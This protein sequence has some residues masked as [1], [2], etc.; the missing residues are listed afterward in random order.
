MSRI[1]CV[2]HM[3]AVTLAQMTRNAPS[4]VRKIYRP[5]D[6][7][8][9]PRSRQN[10]GAPGPRCPQ[11]RA[12]AIPAPFYPLFDPATKWLGQGKAFEYAQQNVN[13]DRVSRRPQALARQA[14][15]SPQ[16][17]GPGGGA[18]KRFSQRPSPGHRADVLA[19]SRCRRGAENAPVL[20]LCASTRR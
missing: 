19:L 20:R 15:M 2:I 10:V 1:A 4:V 9:R 3:S 17:A 14:F 6:P 12:D 16:G 7:I 11:R 18:W 5:M 13:L 8:T